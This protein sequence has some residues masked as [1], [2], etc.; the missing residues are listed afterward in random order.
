MII[1]PK[2]GQQVRLIN[3]LIP[4]RDNWI[5]KT[6]DA[7]MVGTIVRVMSWDH[8]SGHSLIIEFGDGCKLGIEDTEVELICTSDKN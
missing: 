3:T 6:Y 5:N 8:R 1:N 7:G 2:V 4:G